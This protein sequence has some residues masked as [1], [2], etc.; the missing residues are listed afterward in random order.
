M[1]SS[2]V[3]PASLC[4]SAIKRPRFCSIRSPARVEA[5]RTIGNRRC[6]PRGKARPRRGNSR[7]DDRC[8]AV[9]HRADRARHRLAKARR[10]SRPSRL[11]RRSAARQR[12]FAAQ[13]GLRREAP[14]P[15]RCRRIR[16]RP[17]LS[18]PAQT[19]RAAAECA[20]AARGLDRRSR[21]AG[22]SGYRRSAPTDRR[23]PRRRTNWRRFPRA[24]AP[25]KRAGRDNRRPGA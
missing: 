20:G 25:D 16:R 24:A 13:R 7:S 9:L 2:S 21:S 19:D 11:C 15:L 22:A 1:Q 12:R 10:A 18:A 5:R 3:L 4:S 17:N 23:R 14:R 6:I 8:I